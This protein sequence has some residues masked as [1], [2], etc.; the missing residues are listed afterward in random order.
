MSR[1]GSPPGLE[2]SAIGLPRILFQSVAMMAPAAGLAFSL[3]V[4]IPSAGPTLPLSV[5]MALVGCLFVAVGISMLA[6]IFP[7]AGSLFT[8]IR[9][10][11]NSRVGAIFGGVM[12]LYLLLFVPLGVLL[13]P[14]LVE[15]VFKTDFGFD[16]G[17]LP[18]GVL[19]AVVVAVLGYY[20]LR[21][22]TGVTV[23]L[24]A[25][26]VAIFL[27]LSIW[28]ITKNG[29]AVSLAP[30]DPRNAPNHSISG[31]MKGALYGILAFTGFEGAAA[32]GAEGKNPRRTIPV[33]IFVATIVI[34]AFLFF[35]TF[36][37]VFGEGFHNFTSFTLS[38]SDPWVA[39]A[40]KYWGVG[41]VLIFI[42]ILNSILATT[43]AGASVGGRVFYSLG[44]GRLLPRQ[45]AKVHPK[46]RT[47]YVAILTDCAVG[48]VIAVIVGEVWGPYPAFEMIA[49]GVSLFAVLV[50][51]ATSVVAVIYFA[52][53]R[54]G[55]FKWYFH[56]LLPLLGAAMFLT[57]LYFQFVP[58]PPAP[59]VYANWF[60]L[61][62][63]VLLVVV[64]GVL[65]LTRK[66]P[67]EDRFNLDVIIEDSEA[68]PVAELGP[69]EV[70]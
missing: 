35:G 29:S 44:H 37:S 54:K 11:S 56:G 18:W 39:V 48:L 65:Y 61:A 63:F 55:E 45:V 5:L 42:A 32:Y 17:W 40:T 16:I 38:S 27:A 7:S 59:I 67:A 25:F 22:S 10:G 14:I 28:M 64:V 24:A 60:A 51:V 31:V 20:G 12:G 2:S 66:W 62:A 9:G 30:F 3:T 4:G 47:P 41:W 57:A 1:T 50:Y 68:G 15:P 46:H 58:L 23:A 13:I 26:E 52:R 6:K 8:F 34:G 49:T 19:V 43:I 53:H 33:A 70:R 21:L 36:A 69:A